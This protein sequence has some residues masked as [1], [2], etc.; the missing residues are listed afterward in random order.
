MKTIYILRHAEAPSH[1]DLD[2]FDRP[3]SEK[4]I[5]DAAHLGHVM[6][7]E[8]YI[9]EYV[10]CSPA[11]RTQ[12]TLEALDLKTVN[13][14]TPDN[15]Y[16][17]TAGDYFAAIQNIGEAH[18]KA[19]LVGHN[20]SVHELVRLLAQYRD[21]V[22]LMSYSPCT[23]TVLNINIQKWSDLKPSSASITNM[24]TAQYHRSSG[25]TPAA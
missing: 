9:P 23:F 11:K 19:L 3:L 22:R 21:D 5:R 1:P 17:G 6:G 8:R 15:L 16:T 12:M 18:E 20:P 13:I 2:D 25:S 24:I 14:D 10:L 7:K 4:G